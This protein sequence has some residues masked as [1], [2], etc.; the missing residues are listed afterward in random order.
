MKVFYVTCPS[1]NFKYYVGYKLVS[2]KGFPTICPRCH[3]QYP[4]EK[5][6][7]GVQG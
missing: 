2:L 1:C 6:K 7:T 4:L 5:S 3:L